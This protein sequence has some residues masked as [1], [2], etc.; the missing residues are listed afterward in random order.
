MV[1]IMVVAFAAI[2]LVIGV[3]ASR[4]HIALIIREIVVEREERE[5]GALVIIEFR[6]GSIRKEVGMVAIWLVRISVLGAEAAVV[7]MVSGMLWGRSEMRRFAGSKTFGKRREG[8]WTPMMMVIIVAM[9]EIVVAPWTVVRVRMH[10]WG[11]EK[12]DIRKQSQCM[13]IDRL[14]IAL[15]TYPMP[16]EL[17]PPGAR[18]RKLPV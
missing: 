17:R 7:V 4:E 15:C 13:I 18:Q 5:A 9:L 14:T 10:T 16:P 8:K 12:S 1:V 11:N 6:Q 3:I 2:T